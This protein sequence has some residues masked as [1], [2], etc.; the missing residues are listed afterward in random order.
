MPQK[1]LITPSLKWEELV[2]HWWRLEI[3]GV[4]LAE[5][6]NLPNAPP[7]RIP[8][9]SASGLTATVPAPWLQP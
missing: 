3:T 8:A 9:A 6:G 2:L 7:P 4:I 1:T 5:G